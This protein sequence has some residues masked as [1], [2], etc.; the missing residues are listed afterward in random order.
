MNQHDREFFLN[1]IPASQA[2]E[3]DI[4]RSVKNSKVFS[5]IDLQTQV[6]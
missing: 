3:V 4:Y 5:A 2:L 6:T 1:L